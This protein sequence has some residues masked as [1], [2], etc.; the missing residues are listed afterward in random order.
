MVHKYQ[1]VLIDIV[2]CSIQ[3]G[4]RFIKQK[5][6][7]FIEIAISI[8][9]NNLTTTNLD[10]DKYADWKPKNLLLR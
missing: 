2:F 7:F 4:K 8:G 5:R 3:Q 9:G 1:N 10:I 6:L